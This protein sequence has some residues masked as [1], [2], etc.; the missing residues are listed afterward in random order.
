MGLF[1]FHKTEIKD[2]YYFDYFFRGDNR[3]NFSKTFVKE[4]LKEIGIDFQVS[5]TFSSKS[6]K[7]VIRGL[8]FQT[9]NPQA[10][11][12][13]VLSGSIWDV[14]VDLRPNSETYK[15]WI[16]FELNDKNH[17]GVYVPRGFAHGFLSKEDNTIMLY[18][19][20]GEYDS[21]TDTGIRFDDSELAI[22]WPIDFQDTIHSE[23]D[24]K[25]QDF[26]SYLQHPMEL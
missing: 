2:V 21:N 1:E 15:K 23:R 9:H 26:K 16:S 14:I 25:L 13:T 3:G 5:E 12:V 6:S 4:E 24:L 17:K 8:H 10:K 22:Q 11:I 19:C 20:D 7:N 18:Q